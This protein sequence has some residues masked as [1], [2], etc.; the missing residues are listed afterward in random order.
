MAGN[1]RTAAEELVAQQ[2][3]RAANAQQQQEPER[4]TQP[5]DL[6][7]QCIV[8]VWHPAGQRLAVVMC[9]CSVL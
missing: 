3:K 6:P 4:Q 8:V 7:L 2:A 9:C 5:Q 1:R